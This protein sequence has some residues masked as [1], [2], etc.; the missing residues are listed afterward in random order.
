M[1]FVFIFLEKCCFAMENLVTTKKKLSK[2]SLG[3]NFFIYT[4]LSAISNFQLEKF[5]LAMF[6]CFLTKGKPTCQVDLTISTRLDQSIDS[7]A[8]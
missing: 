6:A 4:F 2:T 5:I 8:L 7:T 1:A 3:K